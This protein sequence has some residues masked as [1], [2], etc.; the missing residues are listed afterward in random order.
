MTVNGWQHAQAD[1]SDVWLR[2]R[3]GPHSTAHTT[4]RQLYLARRDR[5]PRNLIGQAL[6]ATIYPNLALIVPNHWRSKGTEG[7]DLPGQQSG[8]AAKRAANGGDKGHQTS[9]DFLRRQNCIIPGPR[10]LTSTFLLCMNYSRRS[11]PK[12]FLVLY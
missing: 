2:Y 11:R 10:G 5:D 4:S 7:A 1:G 9:L 3:L 6:Q 8:G 12:I